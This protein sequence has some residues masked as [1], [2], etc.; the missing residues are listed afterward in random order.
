MRFF[1]LK[2]PRSFT[3]QALMRPL[4][5][6]IALA[7]VLAIALSVMTVF[8]VREDRQLSH[9]RDQLK[10]SIQND[11]S[12]VLRTYEQVSLPRADVAGTLLPTMRQHLYSAYSLNNVLTDVY[13]AQHSILGNEF[14]TQISGAMDEIDRDISSGRIIDYASTALNGYMTEMQSVL[15]T[16]FGA[17]AQT[18]LT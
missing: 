5:I 3:N 1:Q 16:E 14:Y 13:G 8:K 10:A 11:L 12:M 18:A 9:G 6:T 17:G 2:R 7:L 4:Y 15:A